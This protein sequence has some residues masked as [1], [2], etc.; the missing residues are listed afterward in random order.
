MSGYLDETEGVFGDAA[1]LLEFVHA[2]A[3]AFDDPLPGHDFGAHERPVLGVDEPLNFGHG[4]FDLIERGPRFGGKCAGEAD[5]SLPLLDGAMVGVT[6][7]HDFAAVV[8][9]AHHDHA[10]GCIVGTVPVLVAVVRLRVQAA[11]Q[12]D[13]RLRPI[14]VADGPHQ[15]RAAHRAPH[16][17]RVRRG[18]GGTSG[19]VSCSLASCSCICCNW[20]FSALAVA[21]AASSRLARSSSARTCS[22]TVDGRSSRVRSSA[23]A[24]WLLPSLDS[25]SSSLA[26][27]RSIRSCSDCRSM[28]SSSPI[29]GGLSALLAC[30]AGGHDGGY[31]CGVEPDDG[32]KL[33]EQQIG[34]VGPGLDAG[35][36]AALLVDIFEQV[37][38][39]IPDLTQQ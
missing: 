29:G 23:S 11:H 18:G 38:Q 5:A 24:C 17:T 4:P 28:S 33:C 1:G 35:Q 27:I 36:A 10:V 9:F 21:A 7:R 6:Q 12:L 26:S 20:D 14:R 3:V 37:H 8:V 32:L 15:A 34:A 2:D 22:S 39:R 16:M 13:P 25:S 30:A 31:G 19:G